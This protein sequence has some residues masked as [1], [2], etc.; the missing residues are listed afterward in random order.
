MN[1]DE[2]QNGLIG[3]ADNPAEDDD[4]RFIP[5]HQ[6]TLD[7]TDLA[8]ARALER[9]GRM[10][11]LELSRQL[12]VSRPTVTE[13]LTRLVEQGVIRGFHA[14]LDYRRLGYPLMAFVGLQT[15]QGFN[16]VDVIS[17]LKRIREVEEVHTVAGRIDMLVKVRARSTEHLQYILTF[18][19]QSIPGIGRGET[20]IALSSSLEWAPIGTGREIPH[21]SQNEKNGFASETESSGGSDEL[22][23]LNVEETDV[24]RNRQGRRTRPRP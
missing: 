13:R 6:P 10:S 2:T 3:D 21:D 11:I 24:S 19:I 23:L 15:V 17:A 16:A 22:S 14:R 1:A 20:M 12:G 4:Q 9:D 18:K 5:A 7:D 8:I